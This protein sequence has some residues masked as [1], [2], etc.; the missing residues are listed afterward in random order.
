MIIPIGVDCGMANFC[1]KY[2]LRNASL[3]F[4]WTVS[5]NGVSKC[6]EDDFKNFTE[7]LDNKIN[8]FDVYFMHDFDNIE[9]LNQDR[10]KY[11]RR[12]QRLINILETTNEEVIFCRKGHACHQH[13]EHNGKYNNIISDIDDAE[14][15]DVVISKK[16]PKLKYKI[17]VILVCGECFN[18]TQEYKSSSDNIE[19]YN[20]AT[21]KVDDDMFEKCCR[22][23]LHC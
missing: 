11:I 23:I 19:I 8:Q 6:I 14:K 1:K 4:D 12:C 13:H 18:P 9:L 21:P 10:E 2:N 7:P 5:Y 15:L 16:Y 22:I 3:P 20:I 17:I